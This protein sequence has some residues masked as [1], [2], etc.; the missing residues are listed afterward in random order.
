MKKIILSIAFMMATVV[1]VNAQTS[2]WKFAYGMSFAMGETADFSGDN[3]FRGFT[4][5]GRGF[6]ADNVSIGGMWSWEVF[7]EVKRGLP[8]QPIYDDAGNHIGDQ[9]GTPYT[10]LNTMPI[11]FNGHYYLG[12]YG[13]VRT[14]FGLGIGPMYVEQREDQGFFT[15]QTNSWRF[16][17]QPEV[18]VFIPFGLS[19]AGFDVRL[20]YRYATKANN[21]SNKTFPISMLN[22]TVGFGF[23]N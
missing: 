1:A 22:L 21:S 12:D 2:Y 4:I 20:G 19:S 18:G 10:Y 6:L 13:G 16:A 8:P 17:A 11:L 14:Y 15:T 9:S 23:M 7:D 3:S 5:E